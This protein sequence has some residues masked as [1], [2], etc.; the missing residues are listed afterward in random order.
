MTGQT[1]LS[2]WYDVRIADSYKTT[3][4]TWKE[5]IGAIL[6]SWIKIDEYKTKE[7]HN[8]VRRMYEGRSK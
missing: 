5:E 1:G 6:T 3:E 8:P 2:N 7:F 4:R